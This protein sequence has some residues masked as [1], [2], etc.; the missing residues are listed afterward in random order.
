MKARKDYYAILGV[1]IECSFS[2]VKLAYRKL[3]KL[4]HPDLSGNHDL[5]A[6]INEAYE[7]LKDPDKR[8]AY[9]AWIEHGPMQILKENYDRLNSWL[10]DQIIKSGRV[11]RVKVERKL[12]SRA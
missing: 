3:A 9:D 8:D 10:S 6:E 7:I 4:H 1:D 2:E 12:N 11:I 5:F